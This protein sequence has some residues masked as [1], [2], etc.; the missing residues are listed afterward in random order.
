MATL[1]LVCG[2][3]SCVGLCRWMWC[4]IGLVCISMCFMAQCVQ[5]CCVCGP[6]VYRDIVFVGPSVYEHM[7]HRSNAYSDMICRPT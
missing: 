4:I 6:S 7:R 2:S 3:M 1:D 5:G